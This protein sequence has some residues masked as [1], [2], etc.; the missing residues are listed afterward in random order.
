[1]ERT[2]EPFLH[3]GSAAAILVDG[4]RVGWVGEIHPTVAASW[5]LD[6]TAAAFELDLDA[7]A[8]LP[9]AIFEDV[10]S[11]PEV[12]EDLAVVV[13]DGVTAAQVLAVARRAGAPLL[14][15]AEVFDL[16]RNPERL[17]EG[18]VSLA[19]RLAYRA[20]DRTLTDA[21]VAAQREAIAQALADEL[22]G[23][24]RAGS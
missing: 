4:E 7:L 9:T 14:Y 24:I 8:E 17:G 11:F 6:D 19:L 3:P 15:R 2:A 22:Q 12:R 13:A 20:P 1:V 10:T 5:D 21:E 16:Y 23:R 18:N